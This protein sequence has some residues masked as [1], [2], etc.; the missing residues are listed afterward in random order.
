M[1]TQKKVAMGG[2]RPAAMDKGAALEQAR[3][4]RENREAV[5]RREKASL[6]IQSSWRRHHAVRTWRAAELKDW[7]AKVA[8]VKKITALLAAAGRPFAPPPHVLVQLLRVAVFTATGSDSAADVAR[9]SEMAAMV[10]AAV[11]L[12]TFSPAFDASAG[13]VPASQ[14]ASVAFGVSRLLQLAMKV[15]LRGNRASLLSAG[16]FGTFT[17]FYTGDAAT[18]ALCAQL[19][20]VVANL[21]GA[22][23][24]TDSGEGAP[25]ATAAAAAT[26]G[27]SQ[28]VFERLTRSVAKS[29]ARSPACLAFLSDVSSL[30]VSALPSAQ[31]DGVSALSGVFTPPL[32]GTVASL[33]VRGLIASL[34]DAGSGSSSSSGNV[35]RLVRAV[36]S[37][38]C[39][40]QLPQVASQLTAMM[41]WADGWAAVRVISGILD[42]LAGPAPATASAAAGASG[43]SSVGARGPLGSSSA[44]LSSSSSSSSSAAAA[45]TSSLAAAKTPVSSPAAEGGGY[46]S[47]LHPAVAAAFQLGNVISLHQL[48]RSA[49]GIAIQQHM[50]HRLVRTYSALLGKMPAAA[51]APYI[52]QLSPMAYALMMQASEGVYVGSRR[53][54]SSPPRRAG[55][56]Y[57][58][59]HGDGYEDDD[60]YMADLRA[61]EDEEGLRL[62]LA[63]KNA[64]DALLLRRTKTASSLLDRMNSVLTFISYGRTLAGS[65]SDV[66]VDVVITLDALLNDDGKAA[67]A[68]GNSS[69]SSGGAAGN[70]SSSSGGYVSTSSSSV[71]GLGFGYGN[72]ASAKGGQTSG[73]TGSS[74]GSGASGSGAATATG[75]RSRSNSVTSS[76]SS[77]SSSALL[78]PVVALSAPAALGTAQYRSQLH[79]LFTD[80]QLIRGLV[81]AALHE[82]PHALSSSLAAAA[83]SLPAT[84]GDTRLSSRGMAALSLLWRLH[85]CHQLAEDCHRAA[86]KAGAAVSPAG[87]FHSVTAATAAAAPADASSSSSSPEAASAIEPVTTDP[88]LALCMQQP[89]RGKADTT[90]FFGRCWAALPHANPATNPSILA[91]SPPG[92]ALLTSLCAFVSGVNSALS[93]T[94]D[95]HLKEGGYPF[96]PSQLKEVALWAKS[97]LYWAAWADPASSDTKLSKRPLTSL[98]LM[99]GLMSLLQELFDRHSRNPAL[100]QTSDEDWLWPPLPASDLSADVIL[101]IA[102]AEVV[103]EALT[104]AEGATPVPQATTPVAGAGAGETPAVTSSSS[105]AAAAASAAVAPAP[106]SAAASGAS[107]QPAPPLQPLA[108]PAAGGVIQ[109]GNNNYDGGLLDAAAAGGMGGGGDWDPDDFDDEDEGEGDGGLHPDEMDMLAAMQDELRFQQQLQQ[110]GAQGA[111]ARGGGGGGSHALLAGPQY[112]G[113]RGIRQARAQMILTSVPFVIPFKTRVALFTSLRDR[114]REAHTAAAQAGVAA[115]MFGF[116]PNQKIGVTIRR[117]TLVEDAYKAFKE[118]SALPSGASGSRLKDPLSITFIN[119]EGLPEAGIDG[120]GLMKEFVDSVVKEAFGTTAGGSLTSSSSSS[121]SSSSPPPLF[122]A[123]PDHLL[124][125]NPA[126]RYT[127]HGNSSSNNGSC[128]AASSSSFNDPLSRLEFLGRLLGKALYEGILV[129]PRF[130]T[131]FLRKLLGR[132]NSLDDLSS[133]DPHLHRSLLSLKWMTSGDLAALGLTFELTDQDETGRHHAIPLVPGGGELA[134]TSAN[135]DSYIR[136]VAHHRLNVQIGPQVAAFLRG[137]RDLLPIPWL[138]MFGPRELQL[139]LGG[140][141]RSV[142]VSD[143]R[144]NTGYSGGYHDSQPYIA[145][146]WRVLQGF[147]DDDMRAFLAFTTSCSRPPLL[148]FSALR[149]K[150]GIT[151]VPISHD[152]ERLPSAG[153]CFNTLKLPQYSS[154]EVLRAKLLMAIHSGA[155]FE[156][157]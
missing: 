62:E 70:S 91:A 121:S 59:G 141:E 38:P 65:S 139:L 15:L 107:G 61:E 115:A 103:D 111:G 42:E 157:S 152:N 43:A 1:G 58:Y 118:I 96:P 2:K 40:M 87:P 29:A 57:S 45:F 56:A 37:T 12:P 143:L 146:F 137:F 113:N 90:F 71:G 10:V 33:A 131:F 28:P 102:D 7:D 84:A 77:I 117:A 80:Q 89:P 24:T 72:A 156:L 53:S 79:A 122:C 49:D 3:K 126:A 106:S 138:R 119:R 41:R 85:Q 20:E 83:A 64:S 26:R 32:M 13:P 39:L 34:A 55:S 99:D 86:L 82:D 52:Q 148:G 151:R 132:A 149:P 88:L 125:P 134:V 127:S 81:E 112:G 11:K 68:S 75:K 44:F 140:S 16:P 30:L 50:S 19:S 144:A 147:S 101:G 21:T 46:F 63:E 114:D 31:S 54:S 124:Y 145:S 47:S 66:G 123:T 18:A 67:P 128:G 25:A 78:A 153:T 98:V 36:F 95:I 8:D 23:F 4:E 150:F 136:L 130:A 94:D 92:R 129:E 93:R 60:E 6:V 17:L 22:Q 69:I 5:R 133:L 155:G 51:F 14:A 154:E 105:S 9:L 142:D 120:G 48:M 110:H 27:S 135:V 116:L 76:S 73:F 109:V 35:G 108:G 74:S 104:M 97:L 100:L